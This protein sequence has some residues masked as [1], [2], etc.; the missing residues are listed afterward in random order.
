MLK[1]II[2]PLVPVILAPYLHQLQEAAQFTKTCFAIS[3]TERAGSNSYNIF[4]SWETGIWGQATKFCRKNIIQSTPRIHGYCRFIF[5]DPWSHL[6][7]NKIQN[8]K[9]VLLSALFSV[10]RCGF[11]STVS[12]DK[13]ISTN[14]ILICIKEMVLLFFIGCLSQVSNDWSV[15]SVKIRT[16]LIGLW[17]PGYSFVGRKSY[18]KSPQ[19]PGHLIR[20]WNLWLLWKY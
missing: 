20:H 19:F 14:L 12:K 9:N 13:P 8:I 10:N 11:L 5:V 17:I 7:S 6:M 2:E 1:T 16:K 15:Y 3:T 18:K 4:L